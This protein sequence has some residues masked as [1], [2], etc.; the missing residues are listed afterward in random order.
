LIA[1]LE[2]QTP[3]FESRLRLGVFE[4]MDNII[5]KYITD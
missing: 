3:G 2:A 4:T 5:D 1:K